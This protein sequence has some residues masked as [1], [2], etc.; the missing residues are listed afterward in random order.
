MGIAKTFNAAIGLKDQKLL[1]KIGTY[2]FG[3]GT[4]FPAMETQYRHQCKKEYFNKFSLECR[5]KERSSKNKKSKKIAFGDIVTMI[6]DNY[7]GKNNPMQLTDLLD[8]HKTVYIDEDGDE[9]KLQ[10]FNVQNLA[11]KSRK[12]IEES[13]LKIQADLTRKITV[14]H[15][16]LTNNSSLNIE[17]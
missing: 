14:W 15:G 11:K 3:F 6:N 12:K 13:E 16:D 10:R 7:I 9:I 1:R 4:N 5:Q 17:K 8:Y 2:D